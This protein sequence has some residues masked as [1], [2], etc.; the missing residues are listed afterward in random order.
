MPRA[1]GRP[2]NARVGVELDTDAFFEV[3]YRALGNL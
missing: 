3:L 2:P 1:G